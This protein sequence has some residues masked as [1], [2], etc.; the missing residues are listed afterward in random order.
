[1]ETGYQRYYVMN[2]LTFVSLLPKLKEGDKP[3]CLSMYLPHVTKVYEKN[4]IYDFNLEFKRRGISQLNFI[5]KHKMSIHLLECFVGV[6][7][8]NF[9]FYVAFGSDT[10]YD[11]KQIFVWLSLIKP[12]VLTFMLNIGT[13]SKG[14]MP[15]LSKEVE[16]IAAELGTFNAYI[17]DDKYINISGLNSQK[18]LDKMSNFSCLRFGVE[19]IHCPSNFGYKLGFLSSSPLIEISIKA[20][21]ANIAFHLLF[22]R[23]NKRVLIELYD[24]EKVVNV[25]PLFILSSKTQAVTLK[26]TNQKISRSELKTTFKYFQTLFYSTQRHYQKNKLPFNADEIDFFTKHQILKLS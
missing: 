13:W 25:L 5:Y 10:F 8:G 7:P 2:E 16:N 26:T 22:N 4:L 3:V 11:V 14:F 17:P 1:M 6:V 12:K 23:M 15:I 21:D 18:V 24:V 20:S 19:A 9:K